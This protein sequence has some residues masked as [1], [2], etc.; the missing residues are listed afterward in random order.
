MPVPGEAAKGAHH[1]LVGNY[2]APAVL[3]DVSSNER[4]QCFTYRRL[5]PGKERAHGGGIAGDLATGEARGRASRDR[6]KDAAL[7]KSVER[8]MARG[9]AARQ[10]ASDGHGG[11][12]QKGNKRARHSG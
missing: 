10:S 4:I 2:G 8:G 5:E 7:S 6:T 3:A 1:E 12:E 11:E 9:I